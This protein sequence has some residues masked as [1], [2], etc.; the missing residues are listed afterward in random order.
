MKLK[1]AK[2]FVRLLCPADTSVGWMGSNVFS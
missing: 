1:F 2:M